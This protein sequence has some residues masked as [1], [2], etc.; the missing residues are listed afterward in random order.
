MDRANNLPPN[1]TGIPDV[2]TV[3]DFQS[4]I[5]A[6]YHK[7]TRSP[8][9]ESERK[10]LVSRVTQAKMALERVIDVLDGT[11]EP[12]LSLAIDR[13]VELRELAEYVAAQEGNHGKA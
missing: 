12:S 11:F 1:T 2:Y 3:N 6:N 5:V 4:R 7:G 8:R 9:F 10:A 13:L